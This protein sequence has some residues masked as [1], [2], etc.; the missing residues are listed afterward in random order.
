MDKHMGRKRNSKLANNEDKDLIPSKFVKKDRKLESLTKTQLI[1]K[2]ILL[3]SS[4]IELRKSKESSDMEISSLKKENNEL[5]MVCEKK[6]D[7]TT[8]QTHTQTYPQN[9]FDY[10]C[11]VC[12][13]QSS[14]EDPLWSHMDSE[15]DIQREKTN[16]SISCELC[17]QYF[18]KES[19][20]KYHI[21]MKHDEMVK[22][23][24][25]FMQGRCM[26]SD[27]DCWN[28]HNSQNIQTIET[29][30]EFYCQHCNKVFNVKSEFM[31]HRKQQHLQ[32]VALCRENNNNKCRFKNE[33]WYRHITETITN[34]DNT[35]KILTHLSERIENME[36]EIQM[37][38]N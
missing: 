21:K 33:C 14:S 18:I 38:I 3:E 35:V 24:K 29:S 7:L 20:L 31:K 30:I 34:N 2:C 10:N 9:D 5:K 1:Q 11:G 25:Y 27:E 12:V 17:H 28:S 15:H 23:C 16:E 26:F 13:F 22:P 8:V 4:I 37:Q 32:S 6:T 19:D 36:R